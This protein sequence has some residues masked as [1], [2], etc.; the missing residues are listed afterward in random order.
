MATILDSSWTELRLK[1]S[2]QISD[3][4]HTNLMNAIIQSATPRTSSSS[5]VQIAS[6]LDR[7]SFRHVR[8]ILV[9]LEFI[10]AF[11]IG[12]INICYD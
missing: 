1:T 11:F 3:C 9:S 12:Q 6:N 2:T 8:A 10:S 7:F 4:T 5:L